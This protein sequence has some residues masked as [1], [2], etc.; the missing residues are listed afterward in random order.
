MQN[1]IKKKAKSYI[2]HAYS[3]KDPDEDQL[4]D[5]TV[6]YLE[7]F[8]DAVAVEPRALP[9]NENAVVDA[10]DNSFA[11]VVELTT[12]MTT[13]AADNLNCVECEFVN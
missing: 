13:N 2:S 11:N 3:D 1:R 10:D 6:M 5:A 12:T 7:Y 4:S 9:D 8:D